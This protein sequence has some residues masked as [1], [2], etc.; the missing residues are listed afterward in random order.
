MLHVTSL[1][2]KNAFLKELTILDMLMETFKGI[3]KR[4][5]H[6]LVINEHLS[7]R[8]RHRRQ[9]IGQRLSLSG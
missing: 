4:V 7:I 2:T 8:N 9:F 6:D 3:T 1:I 5:D